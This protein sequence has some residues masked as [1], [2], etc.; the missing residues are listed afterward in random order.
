VTTLLLSLWL[1]DSLGDASP[2]IRAGEDV[3][4]REEEQR[5]SPSRR[6]ACQVPGYTDAQIV[7]QIR[8]GDQRMFEALWRAYWIPLTQ[9]ATT[10]VRDQDAAED[11]VAA[12]L[13]AVWEHHTDWDVR[14]SVTSYLVVAI[15]HRALNVLRAERRRA[16][17]HDYTDVDVVPTFFESAADAIDAPTIRARVAA[18]VRALPGSARAV[19]LL[20]WRYQG[21]WDEIAAMLG[22]SVSAAKVQHHRA[23]KALRAALGPALDL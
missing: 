5:T 13:G 15:R 7:A 20:R 6:V 23:L 14:G 12:L 18:A 2:R 16:S 10:Y 21:S 11:L 1:H 4:S 17:A 3:S 8:A 19:L 22:V 9:L